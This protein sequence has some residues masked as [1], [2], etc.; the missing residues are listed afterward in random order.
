MGGWVQASKQASKAANESMFKASI[1][2]SQDLVKQSAAPCKVCIFAHGV[3]SQSEW[4]AL[5]TSPHQLHGG[6][7]D[8]HKG[9]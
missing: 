6:L 4:L 7:V 1:K 3:V 8:Q 5:L 2:R 9:L